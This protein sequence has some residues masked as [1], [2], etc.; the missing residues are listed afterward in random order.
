MLQAEADT[1][2]KRNAFLMLFHADQERAVRFLSDN[3]DQVAGYGDTLQ[4]VI[5]ELIRKV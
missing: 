5:L 1:S 3:L 4:L 2:C